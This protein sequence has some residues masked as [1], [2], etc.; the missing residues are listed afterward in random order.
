VPVSSTLHWFSTLRLTTFGGWVADCGDEVAVGPQGWE[1]AAQR[2]EFPAQQVR[3]AAL[4]LL[5]QPV[6]AALRIGG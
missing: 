4:D 3:V 2:R 5:D 1:A 6:D